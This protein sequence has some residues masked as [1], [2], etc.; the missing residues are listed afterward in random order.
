MN[1]MD[2]IKEKGKELEA[3]AKDLSKGISQAAGVKA[4]EIKAEPAKFIADSAKTI[5]LTALNIGKYAVDQGIP[6]YVLQS[7][8][9]GEQKLQDG[10][11]TEEQ[12]IAF[13][14]RRLKAAEGE[15][16]TLRR[17]LNRSIPDKNNINDIAA[18]LSAMEESSSRLDCYLNLPSFN[19][20]IEYKESGKLLQTKALQMI[21]SLRDTKRKLNAKI[22]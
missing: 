2:K 18:R 9:E 11:F 16:K 3:V 21:A 6:A 14:E 4:R 15:I 17:L 7:I 10:K 22:N 8:K 1:F 13:I 12:R 5:G 20:E 19:F